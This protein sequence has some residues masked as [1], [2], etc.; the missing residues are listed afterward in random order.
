MDVVVMLIFGVFGYYLQKHK[1]PLAC[2]ILGMILGPLAEDSFCRTML[3]S[4]YSLS[5]FVTR[6]ISLILLLCIVFS[7]AAGPLKKLIRKRKAA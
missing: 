6:P 4:R 5:V 1:Y 3:L 2:L 7:F